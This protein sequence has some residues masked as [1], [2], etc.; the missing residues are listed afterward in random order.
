MKI[1]AILLATATAALAQSSPRFAI[2]KST[3]DGGGARSAA[4]SRFALTGTIA[5]A[6]AAPLLA[7]ASGRFGLQPGFWGQVTPVQTPGAPELS[8]RASRFPGF[9]ILAWPVGVTNY[10]LQQSPDMS[11][12]SWTY[13]TTSV[14][15]S[16]TE[17]TVLM[18]L[19]AP[20]QFFRLAIPSEDR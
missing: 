18:P 20:S 1:I 4:A 17:H 2:T 7:S 9:I 11:T 19:I 5:Q 16:A 12:G 15:D 10:V 8:I 3:I 6:E 14:I 13:V